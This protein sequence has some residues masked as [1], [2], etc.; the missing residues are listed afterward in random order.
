MPDFLSGLCT[1]ECMKTFTSHLLNALCQN[2][3]SLAIASS[4][5]VIPIIEPDRVLGDEPPIDTGWTKLH[6][7]VV[8]GPTTTEQCLRNGCDPNAPDKDG[9]TALHLA[10]QNALTDTAKLLIQHGAQ[11]EVRT[12]YGATPLHSAAHSNSPATIDLLLKQGANI[13]SIDNNSMTPLAYSVRWGMAKS[14]RRLLEEG[15]NPHIKDKEGR[16]LLALAGVFRAE[17]T[18]TAE[19]HANHINNKDCQGRPLS[20]A[21]ARPKKLTESEVRRHQQ[22]LFRERERIKAW[23]I[24]IVELEKA[25]ND[26]EARNRDIGQ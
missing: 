19:C 7:A 6:H 24:V 14:I 21:W 15:A 8:T 16:G 3:T 1:T 20:D 12:K 13:E 9:E 4:L 17:L 5:F 23:D 10:C 18:R 2:L 22:F 11:L 25:V 26:R